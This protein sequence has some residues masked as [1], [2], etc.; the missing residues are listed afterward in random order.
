MS[1]DHSRGFTL[2][3]LL[4]VIA[5]ITVLAALLFPVFAKA[6]E[7]G[8]ATACLS[9]CRQIGM[10]FIQ[11]TQE[12]D[13]RFPLTSE[14]G[15][16]QSWVYTLQPYISNTQVY[17]CPDDMSR[18]WAKA[19][20]EQTGVRH[21]S[22]SLNE[23]LVGQ[24][25]YTALSTIHNPAALIYIS[26]STANTVGDHFHP[27]FWTSD[28]ARGGGPN[29]SMFNPATNQ[30]LELAVGRHHDGMNNVYTDGHAR[31]SRWSQIWFQ[32]TGVYEGAFDPRQ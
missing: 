31:W 21:S 10:A 16:A 22:Y 15:A 27:F 18:N 25:R 19:A 13:D 5:I 8:Q 14:S 30:T 17:R 26:E 2:I 24:T 29:R 12:Y 4:V 32:G 1:R 11:Y 3:E 28:P 9:N 23:W 6:R 20:F 7:R